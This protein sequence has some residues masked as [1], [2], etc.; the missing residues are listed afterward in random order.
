LLEL[1]FGTNLALISFASSTTSFVISGIPTVRYFADEDRA[2][3]FA[4]QL[5]WPD[6]PS[7]PRCGCREFSYLS[8]RKLWKGKD[9]E[10]RGPS[11]A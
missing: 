4:A 3:S 6:G 11:I 1:G 5:R 8:T 7:C 10:C 2:H 9:R